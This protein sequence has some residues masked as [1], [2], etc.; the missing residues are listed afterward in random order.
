MFGLFQLLNENTDS[1]LFCYDFEQNVFGRKR[2][3]W[4]QSGFKVKGKKPTELKKSYRNTVEILQVAT[5]FKKIENRILL[6]DDD[7][8]DVNLFPEIATDRHGELPKIKFFSSDIEVIEFVINEIDTL[9]KSELCSYSDI[10]ILYTNGITFPNLFEQKF[11]S[12]YG[13]NKLY[14]ATRDRVSK[15]NL[16]ISS[17]SVKLLTVESCKGLEFRILFFIG[18]EE[19]PKNDR[20]EDAERSLAYV[21]MTRAQDLLY[22]LSTSNSGYVSE[23]VEII[24]EFSKNN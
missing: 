5:K 18:L 12:K 20:N 6:P 22:I 19:L 24:N 17:P 3:I 16:D 21:G 4:A 11:I 2:P 1:L 9:V 14:W 7:L 15:L 8:L 13:Q 23:I 10:G